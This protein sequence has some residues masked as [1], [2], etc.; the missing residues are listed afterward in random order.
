MFSSFFSPSLLLHGAAAVGRDVV[1]IGVQGAGHG[2]VEGGLRD[3]GHLQSL[4]APVEPLRVG[5]ERLEHA[6]LP[7]PSKQQQQQ[8]Q[9]KTKKKVEEQ[10]DRRRQKTTKDDKVV[11]QRN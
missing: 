8:Q 2:R 4:A 3:N 1:E 9:Q 5:I 7:P 6:H 10:G 11:S